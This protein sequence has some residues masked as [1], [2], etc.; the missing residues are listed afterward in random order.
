MAGNW[1]EEC[2]HCEA[3]ITDALYKEFGDGIDMY[4]CFEMCCPNCKL[5]MHVEVRI[6]PAFVTHKEEPK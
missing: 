5:S 2:P 1:N 3:K 4:P 6:E